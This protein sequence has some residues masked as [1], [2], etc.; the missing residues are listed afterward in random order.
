MILKTASQRQSQ[1]AIQTQARQTYP[2]SQA[3]PPKPAPMRRFFVFPDKRKR[4]AQGGALVQA[5]RPERQRVT[6]PSGG[7]PLPGWTSPQLGQVRASMSAWNA[8]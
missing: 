4:A 6:Q 7:L 3:I 1:Q 8:S 2:P 5:N